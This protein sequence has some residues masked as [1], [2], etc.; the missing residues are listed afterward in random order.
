MEKPDK[1]KKKSKERGETG[2]R[3]IESG[4]RGKKYD[5]E[6][7][8]VAFWRRVEVKRHVGA[9]RGAC[10]HPRHTGDTSTKTGEETTCKHNTL[11]TSIAKKNRL[12]NYRSFYTNA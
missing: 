3:V 4:G 5:E 6:K 11:M 12:D 2:V 10:L 1:R 8:E 7:E 9:G